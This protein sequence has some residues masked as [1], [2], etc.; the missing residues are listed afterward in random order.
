MI[1][2]EIIMTPDSEN[3]LIEISEYIAKVLL[4]PLT[5]ISYI[6]E[7]RKKIKELEYF[8]KRYKIITK[9]PFYNLKIRG[10]TVKNF[11]VYYRIDEENRIVYILNIIYA[12]RNQLKLLSDK[13]LH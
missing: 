3:D 9:E 13:Y 8:P 6:R 7:I 5:A 4:A 11:L 12:K 2:Y 1:S 10:F